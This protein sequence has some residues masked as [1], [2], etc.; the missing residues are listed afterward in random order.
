MF[1]RHSPYRLGTVPCK[2]QA[3]NHQKT[4][5]VT[6]LI[7]YRIQTKK[8]RRFSLTRLMSQI[9]KHSAYRF[10]VPTFARL[11][12]ILNCNGYLSHFFIAFA[13]TPNLFP[14]C[15]RLEVFN[16]SIS[17]FFVG[18]F[19]FLCNTLK[20]LRHLNEALLIL[21]PQSQQ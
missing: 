2:K 21:T 10:S 14:S 17:S 1:C 3:E 16:I 18:L 19:T 9:T 11:S 7:Y 12:A 4:C 5:F 6:R 13:E 20:H 15:V 8:V